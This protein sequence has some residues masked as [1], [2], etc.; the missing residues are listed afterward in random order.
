MYERVD[1]RE[2]AEKIVNQIAVG[3]WQFCSR[4]W[5]LEMI[6]QALRNE[7]ERCAKIAEDDEEYGDVHTR[8]LEEIR[9][10]N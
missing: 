5:V 1:T 3:A 9:L 4:G 8:C 10:D 7:R 6:D 2:I